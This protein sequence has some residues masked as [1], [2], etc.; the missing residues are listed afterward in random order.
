MGRRP[1]KTYALAAA[2]LLGI[3]ATGC[4]S[5]RLGAQEYV[6]RADRLCKQVLD[7]AARYGTPRTGR[8]IVIRTV[9]VNRMTESVVRR[10]RTLRPPE[11]L[12]RDADR[13]VDLLARRVQLNR[14]LIS[15]ARSG[16]VERLS[17]AG[18][19]RLRL[20]RE[21]NAAAEKAG[22]ANCNAPPEAPA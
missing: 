13:Y 7:T 8:E 14:E 4:G 16:D 11:Y 5:G 15:S 9:A 10:L 20:D 17:R 18:R 6:A 1:L 12:Q 22:F 3:A 21:L 2:A 19:A